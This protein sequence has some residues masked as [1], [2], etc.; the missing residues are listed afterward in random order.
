MGGERTYPCVI[1]L[2]LAL[3]CSN[4]VCPCCKCWEVWKVWKNM[5]LLLQPQRFTVLS[6]VTAKENKNDNS[7]QALQDE[8]SLSPGATRADFLTAPRPQVGNARGSHSVAATIRP[9]EVRR[10]AN[11]TRVALLGRSHMDKSEREGAFQRKYRLFSRTRFAPGST[12][13][14][15]GGLW[16]FCLW[17]SCPVQKPIV[18]RRIILTGRPVCSVGNLETF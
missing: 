4:S 10:S 16:I 13:I 18:P 9:L 5:L 2:P 1:N 3:A 11:H 12:D 6:L 15:Y 7:A 8:A 14:Y 17:G